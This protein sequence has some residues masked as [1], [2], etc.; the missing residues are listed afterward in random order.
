MITI[1]TTALATL[2]AAAAPQQA[3][4]SDR[5]YGVI[6]TRDGATFEGFIRWDKNEGSWD[7]VLNGSK[8]IPSRNYREAERLGGTEQAREEERERTVRFLGLKI[9]WSEDDIDWS[10]DEPSSALSGLRFGH[11]RSIEPAGS[12]RARIVLRSG[13]VVELEGGSGD[14]GNDNRA[15]EIEDGVRGRV[16]LEW[17][18][19][20][21]V[22]LMKAPAGASAARAGDR[23]YGTLRTRRGDEFN[24]YVVWDLDEILGS[25]V[26]DGEERG[27]D[28]EIPFRSIESIERYSSSSSRVRLTNGEEMVLRGTNDVDASNRGIVIS[29]PALG[30][31]TVRW[32]EF[33]RVTFRPV[34]S[35]ARY[36][37][38]DGGRRLRGTV[39]TEDGRTLTGF[40][41]WDNDEEYTW[42]LL[43]GN[44]RGIELDV[45][46]SEIEGI[47]RL[48]SS[49]AL[50]RLRDGRSFELDDSNDVNDGNKGIF[51]TSEGGET[52]M[53]RWRDF[54]D[55]IFARR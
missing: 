29:D 48:S 16:E 13:E 1:A 5:L 31:V 23:L 10:D 2:L 37:A 17:R 7:D 54:R 41:R 14:I 51:V 15:I 47:E 52:V 45:E 44:Y 25:D 6:T 18:D 20:E 22:D 33:D 40:I 36:D 43:D 9:S 53:V 19:I 12:D 49:S 55:V 42:E 38:F 46:F 32:S 39:R 35:D 4:S 24:G 30:Q 26:L 11:I 50:V 8:E 27:R 21:R 3:P 28:R 34:A